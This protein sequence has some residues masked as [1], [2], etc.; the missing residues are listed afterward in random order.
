MA[1][2]EG[3]IVIR[4]DAL[5]VATS[6][7]IRAL[8]EQYRADAEAFVFLSGGA[9]EMPDEVGARLRALLDALRL[10]V[11][12]GL[13]LRRGRRG[14]AGGAHGGSR[15]GPAADRGSLSPAGRGPGGGDHDDGGARPDADRPEPHARRRGGRRGV[16]AAPERGAPARPRTLGVRDGCHVPDLRPARRGRASATLVVNGGAITLDEVG[17]NIAQRRPMV[18]VAGSG[19]VAD[20]LVGRVRGVDPAEPGARQFRDAV[21]SCVRRPTRTSSTSSTSRRAPRGWPSSFG[22][23]SGLDVHR[24]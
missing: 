16:G 8:V 23:G 19:R 22:C 15:P 7:V 18:V 1:P 2:S 20:A 12:G 14:D 17:R 6:P 13:R 4:V 3:P 21:A 10:L 11:D 24:P 9:S 5:A